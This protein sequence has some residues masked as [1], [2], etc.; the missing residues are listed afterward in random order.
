ML[1]SPPRRIKAFQDSRNSFRTMA[2]KMVA[3]DY[4]KEGK[5]DEVV[6]RYA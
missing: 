6:A 1:R 2:A 5:G 3:A 4:D